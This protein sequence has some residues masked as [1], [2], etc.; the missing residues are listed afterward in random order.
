VRVVELKT[1]A[2]LPAKV[3]CSLERLK[4][5]VP[6]YHNG[7]KVTSLQTE[8]TRVTA[9]SS[10]CPIFFMSGV[11]KMIE[12][13]LSCLDGVRTSGKGYT[14]K[15]PAHD[16][17]SPSLYVSQ[18]DDRVLMYCYAGCDIKDI[19]HA[20]GLEVSDLFMDKRKMKPAER[21]QIEV[22][23]STSSK[24]EKLRLD[25]FLA[26][27]DFRKE[28]RELIDVVGVDIGDEIVPAVHMLPKIDY[29]MGILATGT[30][31]EIIEL[32]K[33]GVVGKW[34]KL[35]N[36]QK[37]KANLSQWNLIGST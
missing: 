22:K 33:E 36:S 2:A 15:C 23:Q 37:K 35:T 27:A 3:G 13:V 29:W 24:F 9:E 12:N 28:T 31:D 26:M 10:S 14:A 25:A 18:C 16:D 21:R 5:I 19:C 20:I 34:A 6:L 8:Q 4:L 7:Q 32:I 1:K 17:K 11:E 30:K